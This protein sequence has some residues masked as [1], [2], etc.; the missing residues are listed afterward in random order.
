MGVPRLLSRWVYGVLLLLG[1]AVAAASIAWAIEKLASAPHLV[2]AEQAAILA[3]P[4][5]VIAA[6]FT[7]VP[8]IVWLSRRQRVDLL[9]AAA[10]LARAVRKVDGDE[11]ARLLGGDTVPINLKFDFVPSAGRDAEGMPTSGTFR[12]VVANYQG[13]RPRRMVITGGAGTG[14]TVL[15]TQLIL[16]LL[17]GRGNHDAVPVRLSLA[18]WDTQSRLIDWLT[19]ALADTYDLAPKTVRALVAGGYVIPVL[20]GLD[21]MDPHLPGSPYVADRHSGGL[22]QNDLTPVGAV[23]SR[24]TDAIAQLNDYRVD[25][26]PGA[27]VLTCRDDAYEWLTTVATVKLQDSAKARIEVLKPEQA[28]E[29]LLDRARDHERWWPVCEALLKEDPHPVLTTV[30]DTPWR[31][32]LAFTIYDGGRDPAI[33]LD[34]NDVGKLRDDLLRQYID[35]IAGQHARYHPEHVIGWLSNLARYLQINN[36]MKRRAGDRP[37]S[38]S[39]I[40]LFDLW[41]LGGVNRVCRLDSLIVIVSVICLSSTFMA[42]GLF[43]YYN[44]AVEGLVALA[45]SGL[46][47]SSPSLWPEPRWVDFRRWPLRIA[48]WIVLAAGIGGIWWLTRRFSPLTRA[49]AVPVVVAIALLQ[50]VLPTSSDLPGSVIRPRQVI[51]NSIA[52][53]LLVGVLFG[54]VVGFL[55]GSTTGLLAGVGGWSILVAI[56]GIGAIMA[57]VSTTPLWRRYVAFLLVTRGRMPWRLGRFLDWSTNVGLMRM[58]GTAYQFRHRELQEHLAGKIFTEYKP[59]LS[60]T[61]T[62]KTSKLNRLA[63]VLAL[64]TVWAISAGSIDYLDNHTSLYDLSLGTVTAN[65]QPTVGQMNVALKEQNEDGFLGFV[66][67]TLRPRLRLWWE[68]LHRLG[69]AV[70][71]VYDESAIY[72]PPQNPVLVNSHGD[73]VQTITFV[74]KTKT[75]AVSTGSTVLLGSYRVVVH[76][77]ARDRLGQISSWRPLDSAP[78]DAPVKLYVRRARNAVVVAYP[79]EHTAVDQELISAEKAAKFVTSLFQPNG[80]VLWQRDFF[81]FLSEDPARRAA[82]YTAG[83]TSRWR[84]E[85]DP[86]ISSQPYPRELENLSISANPISWVIADPAS[87]SRGIIGMISAFS[88]ITNGFSVLSDHSIPDWPIIGYGRFVAALYLSGAQPPAPQFDPHPFSYSF[89]WLRAQLAKLPVR[90]LRGGLPTDAQLT[91]GSGAEIQQWSDVAASVYA[92]IS[93]RW[94]VDVSLMTLFGTMADQAPHTPFVVV[95]RIGRDLRYP[96]ATKIESDWKKWLRRYS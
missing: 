44:P 20:D 52:V 56:S 25:G 61:G 9:Q 16:G 29:Y 58:A 50:F 72:I 64:A 96:A 11:Q 41:P 68:N 79:D 87:G 88:L 21:E 31:L 14:K 76:Q 38:G 34:Y 18:D 91:R 49:P 70:N 93:T 19:A 81:V 89:S 84:G 51:R 62:S 92:Y 42:T 17:G 27:L 46:L 28:A 37:L 30:L 40:S 43:N 65:I 59:I 22:E 53:G 8:V 15:A 82:A 26:K 77:L 6:E 86:L 85:S 48:L 71:A 32:N 12:T 54:V 75:F 66:A 35:T 36:A 39:E 3:F 55:F 57:A 63:A 73:A 47:W 7:A 1:L 69:L 83:A 24:M 10:D 60:A 13:L 23:R 90:M 33:L 5:A 67:P 94:G 95:S 80:L 45:C 4:V 2:A 74:G 78:W